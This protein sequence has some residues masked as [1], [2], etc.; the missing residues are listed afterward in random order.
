MPRKRRPQPAKPDLAYFSA[1]VGP[2][3]EMEL[4]HAAYR[5]WH[6]ITIYAKAS[7]DGTC[8]LENI[9]LA[10]LMRGK[11]NNVCS[12]EYVRRLVGELSAIG[13]VSESL[14]D[15]GRR[16]LKPAR[17]DVW[18]KNAAD[19]PRFLEPEDVSFAPPGPANGGRATGGERTPHVVN[20][21]CA[22]SSTLVDATLHDDDR[23]IKPGNNGNGNSSILVD[24]IWS[25]PLD[26]IDL[27][28][29]K[30]LW[31]QF[32]GAIDPVDEAFI[33]E[34][35]SSPEFRQAA[36]KQNKSPTEMMREFI[37]TAAQF[38]AKNPGRYIA[39]MWEN[40][41]SDRQPEE[42]TPAPAAVEPAPAAIDPPTLA[43]SAEETAIWAETQAMLRR[44]MTR[45][46]YDT[47]MAQ[48]SLLARGEEGAVVGVRS[49]MAKEWLENRLKEIVKRALANVLGAPV[50]E[51]Q[52]SLIRE[53]V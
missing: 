23:L 33:G 16:G 45:A 5:L 4:S 34:L 17:A 14:T 48:T 12:R 11:G 29:L 3:L 26:D 10:A 8:W 15:A 36:A 18:A 31:R 37:T 42:E 22:K 52:F 53:A 13:L 30:A 20:S 7:K 21:S 44:Q 38:K 24:G 35:T 6:I 28:R 46:T 19:G 43:D 32:F 39:K 51:I 25:T 27:I 50:K 49:E 47:I 1:P 41:R 9:E 40:R 2:A